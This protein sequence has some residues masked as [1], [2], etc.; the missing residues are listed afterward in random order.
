MKQI[1]L[2]IAI[3]GLSSMPTLAADLADRPNYEKAPVAT[4][5]RWTGFYLGADVGGVWQSRP[6]VD[7]SQPNGFY[8]PMALP[9]SD[10][11]AI[12][13]GLHAG[14]NWQTPSNILLGIEGD[15]TWAN[16]KSSTA[17]QQLTEGGSP[18]TANGAPV[19][20][21]TSTQF[22]WL[23]SVRG[24]LGYVWN[25]VLFYGTGGVAWAETKNSLQMTGDDYK[26]V[27]GTFNKVIDGWVAGGGLEYAFAS[28]WT[29]R[30]EFLHYAFENRS[31]SFACPSCFPLP[32]GRP[33]LASWTN[34]HI[35]EFRAG[36]S[37]QF[38][39]P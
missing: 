24:R 21:S 29:L 13:A 37:Y 1:A 5:H 18:S 32:S 16:A 30:G 4:S 15:F 39:S 9:G 20:V 27:H 36:L 2:A 17:S 19:T 31:Q 23:S 34:S 11:A 12:A 8:D 7:F 14:Y 33:F 35:E 22:D 6:N 38:N 26:S 3:V 28:N 25:N 10:K